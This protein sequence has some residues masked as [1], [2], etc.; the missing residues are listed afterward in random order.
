M[1]E[2]EKADVVLLVMSYVDISK[3]LATQ[4]FHHHH[5]PTSRSSA[6]AAIPDFDKSML[7]QDELAEI[8]LNKV[9]TWYYFF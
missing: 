8:H 3:K 4:C 6:V 9:F 2:A 5:R 7:V 1:K